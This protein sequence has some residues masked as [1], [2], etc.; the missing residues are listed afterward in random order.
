MKAHEKELFDYLYKQ[1]EKGLLSAA[2]IKKLEKAGYLKKKKEKK[3]KK[4]LPLTE[5]EDFYKKQAGKYRNF[6]NNIQKKDWLP[7]S[8]VSHTDD[9][10]DW[11]E[12][13]TWGFFP[14]K[15]QYRPFEIYKAQAYKWLNENTSPLDFANE[16]SYTDV[17]NEECR[18]CDENT[19]YF[20]DKYGYL[21]DADLPQGYRG[22]IAK[23]HHALIFFLLDC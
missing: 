23:E 19:L 22:Y 17:V 1:Y 15:K 9:F 8:I 13:I 14:D 7:A 21:K 2:G 10:Y 5:T 18:R 16:E 4:D 11:V 12:S 3:V 6:G 20:A